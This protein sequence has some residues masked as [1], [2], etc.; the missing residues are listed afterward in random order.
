MSTIGRDP[1]SYYV[2]LGVD[3]DADVPT[4]KSAF[5]ARAKR[6]HPDFNPS[7]IAAKQFHRLHEAYA[8]LI[9]PK[10]RAAYDRPWKT[11]RRADAEAPAGTREKP[12]ERPF[13]TNRS[14]ETRAPEPPPARAAPDAPVVCQC[15]QVTAQ[16]RYILFDMVWG[17]LKR[18]QRRTLGGVYCRSCADRTA[19]RASLV[20]WF[21]GWWAWPDGPRETVRALLNN[22]RGGRKPAD[23]NARL[24]MRQA[25]AFRARGDLELARS[26]ALQA[27]SFAKAAEVRR[28][29]ESLIAALGP[30]GGRVLRDRWARPG[31][32]PSLQ[33]APLALLA[34]AIAMSITIALRQP[35]P[36]APRPVA[37][38]VPPPVLPPVKILRV[39][40]VAA[41]TA[42]LRTGP[43]DAFEVIA[44]LARGTRVTSLET[45]PGG[46]WLRVVLDDGRTGFIA[47]DQ[48]GPAD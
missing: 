38:V 37:K 29:V 23:R 15:G 20:T 10:K 5:R 40:A 6:L 31:W 21:A 32:S 47:A 19:L 24:L 45:D 46:A 18:V 9:D 8:T 35:P 12:R 3:E 39:F 14:G 13:E 44:S 34:G 26:A 11:A 41:E 2:A 33:V 28:D 48:L 36:P 7:P 25:R 1:K 22:I 17:R 16:P 30:P 27:R 4:I 42:P 43:N